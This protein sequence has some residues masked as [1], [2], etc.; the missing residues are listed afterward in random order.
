MVRRLRLISGLVLF[1]YVLTHLLNMALGLV[2]FPVLEAGRQLFLDLWRP[3]L[4]SLLLYGSLLV[5]LALAFYAIFR[6]ESLVMPLVEALRYL[7]GIF[8]IP[9]AALHILGTRLVHEVYGVQDSYLYVLTA[10]WAF[11]LG[12]AVQ[13][14][15]LVLVVWI[16][17]CIGLHLWLRLKSWYPRAAPYG[18]AAAVL[19]P[20]LAL[21]GYLSAG[22]EV[23]RLARDPAF[24]SDVMARAGVPSAAEQG[25]VLALR[26][27]VVTGFFVLLALTLLTREAW[28]FWLRR[29]GMARLTYPGGRA[30]TVRKGQTILAASHLARIP[31]ASVCGGRGRC[32]TCRVRI[33]R[34]GAGLAPP[35]AEEF[36]GLGLA[37]HVSDC[38]GFAE[39]ACKALKTVGLN[40]T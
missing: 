23:L 27:S 24:V 11:D 38:M 8:I 16:H 36:G 35:G 21:A 32:S 34:G 4:P 6:R 40:R 9:L 10:Q 33:G 22:Q 19:V 7:F 3:L 39:L 13:Q 26:D 28:R 18:L 2:S 17:G 1:T 31:H 15:T 20:T 12:F 25:E 37:A 30:V 29:Q 5:H 14:A